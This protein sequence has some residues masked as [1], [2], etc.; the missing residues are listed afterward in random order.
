MLAPSTGA[1]PSVR[2]LM[3]KKAQSLSAALPKPAPAGLSLATL[4]PVSEPAAVTRH[5]SVATPD[6]LA[7]MAPWG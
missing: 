5:C 3:R 6:R 1:P 4:Q 7:S 2:G